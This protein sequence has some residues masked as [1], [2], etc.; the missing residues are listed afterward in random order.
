[1]E[2]QDSAGLIVPLLGFDRFSTCLRAYR[3]R[4]TGSAHAS[5]H[6]AASQCSS[7]IR[8]NSCCAV[9]GQHGYFSGWF[10]TGAI[11][12]VPRLPLDNLAKPCVLS[13][14][15]YDVDSAEVSS[16]GCVNIQRELADSDPLELTWDP[17][18]LRGV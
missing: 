17:T 8:W 12:E 9:N 7:W 1:M 11:D 4:R 2:T 15:V 5:E 3:C 10:Q 13:V 18:P 6:T 14:D 16:R